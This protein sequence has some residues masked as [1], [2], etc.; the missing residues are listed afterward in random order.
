MV[1]MEGGAMNPILDVVVVLVALIAGGV[2]FDMAVR[3][4]HG[5]SH[6]IGAAARTT[7]GVAERNN[8]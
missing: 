6:D 5:Q 4:R 3:R 2:V 1:L 8:M 7:R